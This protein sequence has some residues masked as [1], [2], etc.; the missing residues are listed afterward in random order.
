MA[1]KQKNKKAKAKKQFKQTIRSASQS[2]SRRGADVSRQEIRKTVRKA[3]KAGVGN[4]VLKRNA[5][6][7]ADQQGTKIR[8]GAKDLLGIERSKPRDKPKD[9]PPKSSKT[10]AELFNVGPELEPAPLSTFMGPLQEDAGGNQIVPSGYYNDL[11]INPPDPAPAEPAAEPFDPMA[12][13]Q[14]MLDQ[15]EADRVQRE[16][17][18]QL[19]Y[20]TELSNMAQAGQQA[21]YRFGTKNNRRGGTFGFRRRG[22]LGSQFMGPVNN[23]LSISSRLFNPN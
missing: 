8:S 16:K 3:K 14:A 15:I 4:K 23:A 20:Q 22:A 12:A 2:D 21:D 19:R 5:L 13:F 17:D 10:N 6:K 11:A 1:K 7:I 9:K 18:A